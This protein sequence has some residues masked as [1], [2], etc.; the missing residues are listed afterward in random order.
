MLDKKRCYDFKKHTN[1][2][3]YF[4]ASEVRPT[5]T[6][7]AGRRDPSVAGGYHRDDR[8]TP[9]GEVRVTDGQDGAHRSDGPAEWGLC[10]LRLAVAAPLAW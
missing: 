6:T 4:E 7:T 9:D 3:T 2:P 10:I 1:A 5:S 8:R